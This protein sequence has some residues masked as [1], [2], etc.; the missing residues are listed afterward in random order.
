[1]NDTLVAW[2]T[3][4]TLGLLIATFLMLI[5][6]STAVSRTER[7]VNALLRHSGVDFAVAAAHEARALMQAGNKIEAIKVYREMTGASLADAKAAVEK[8]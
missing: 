4:F 6:T 2:A 5:K 1:M 8:L 7:K 3:G